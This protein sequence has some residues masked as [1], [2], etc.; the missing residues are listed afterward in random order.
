AARADDT[1]TLRLNW[2]IYGFHTPFYLGVEKGIYRKHGIDLTVAEGAGSGRAV[3]T[4]ATG[5]DTF[6]LADGGSIIAGASKGAPV[7][8]VMGIMDTSPYA[9]IVR[10]DSGITDAKGLAGKTIAATTGEAGLNIFPAI[11]KRNN[12]PDD[13]VKFLRVD[14]AAKLVAILENR[15]VGILGGLENQALILPQRGLK[16]TTLSYASMGVNTMGLAIIATKDTIAKNADMVRRFNAATREAFEAAIADPEAAIAAGR[17]AKPDMDHDL[18]LAQLKAG[19]TLVKSPRGK[20]KPVGWM[21][22]DDW[23]D[24][25]ALMKQYQDLKTDLPATAFWTDG[26]LPQ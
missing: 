6:G 15:A 4:V 12:M 7:Q 8:A 24:T 22:P 18:A 25:L 5:S 16:V 17:K 26:L 23:S 2:L 19:L 20:D 3:Q 21:S 9:V 10:A 14:G 1:A 11:L 13:A